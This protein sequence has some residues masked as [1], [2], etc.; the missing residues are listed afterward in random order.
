MTS[1]THEA[2]LKEQFQSG[3][4]RGELLIQTCNNCGRPNPTT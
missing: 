2:S 3:L 4:E 1:V